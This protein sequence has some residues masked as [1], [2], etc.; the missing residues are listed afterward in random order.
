MVRVGWLGGERYPHIVD[1]PLVSLVLINRDYAE[2]IPAA[3]ESIKGQDYP[4]LEVVIVDNGSTDESRDVIAKHVEAD[5]RFRIIALEQNLGQLGAFLDIF[6]L[7]NGEFITIVDADDVLFSNFLSSHLQVHLALPSS[8]ALTSSNVVEMTADAR[9]LTGAHT[10]FGSRGEPITR[11][12][13]PADA[14]LRLSTI[15]DVDYLQLARSTSTHVSW[16]GWIWGPGTSNMYR[17]S[18]L[19]LVHQQPKDRTYFRAADSYLNPLCHVLGGTALID[20]QLSAYRVHGAN[21][22]AARESVLKVRNGRPEFSQRI[23]DDRREL[24]RFLFQRASNFQEIM[25]GPRFWRIVDQLSEGLRHGK[26]GKLLADPRSLE[27]FIHD[28]EILRQA[29]GEADLIANLRRI[30]VSKDLRAVI[31]E[32]HGGRIPPRLRL[33]LLRKG[34][35][36]V[37]AAIEKAVKRAVKKTKKIVAGK[38]PTARK[39][40]KRHLPIEDLPAEF[41]P[42]ATVKK[43]VTAPRRK[44]Q[45][46]ATEETPVE[47]GPVAILSYDPPIFLTG[48]AFEEFTGIAPAFGRTYGSLPAAFLI[49]PCW[50]IENAPRSA[51]VIKA[52]KA[53]LQ[54]HPAHQ[55]MFLC[56]TAAEAELLARGGLNA[57]LLNKNFTVSDEIFRPLAD[58]VVEFDAIYNAR[59]DPQKRHAF[60]REIP[61]VAYVSYAT[62]TADLNIQRELATRIQLQNPNHVLVNALEDGLPIRLPPDQVNAALNRAAVGLCLSN[63]EGSNNAS[64]EYMLAGLPLVSTPSRGGRE[65]FFDHEYCL[66]CDPNPSAVRDAVETLK[67]RNIPPD[68]IRARTLAKIIPERRRF[69]SLVDDLTERLGGKRRYDGVDWP[70]SRSALLLW[71][72]YGDHLLDFQNMRKTSDKESGQYSYADIQNFLLRP[73]ACRC[74]SLRSGSSLRRSNQGLAV[75]CSFSAAGMTSAFWEKVNERGTTAFIEDDPLWADKVR[76]QLK[77]AIVFLVQYDTKKSEWISLLHSPDRLALDLP[78]EVTSKRWDVIVVDGPAGHDNHQKYTGHE[79]PGRMKSIYMASRLIA[80]GGMVFV[81]DCERLVEQQYVARYLASGRLL[82]NTSGHAFLQG[83]AF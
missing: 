31:R 55:L 66:I 1:P 8:V 43:P 33:A 64:M 37:R 36:P 21:Y 56:N 15:S 52:A 32:A 51:E 39:Q 41:E 69:L 50:T 81:H 46:P 27:L 49:Y 34:G 42:T 11:G 67:A 74:S 28:Y 22:F 6:P 38:P 20:R 73:T 14:A 79:A 7:L 78:E 26:K 63:V 30:L 62:D 35:K 77:H 45:D 12:L 23:Q 58:R 9:A 72:N 59:F 47:F 44:E 13:R 80:P 75:P 57:I 82:A 70:F 68:Y 76:G 60:A 40:K 19:A 2:Y 48:I 17:R 3:I 83:Y 53:H 16:G 4:S 71:K 18:I 54:E 10:S 25:S 29:F 24:I 5:S 65:V 61:R